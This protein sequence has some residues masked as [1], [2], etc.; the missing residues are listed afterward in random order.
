MYGVEI[1]QKSGAEQQGVRLHERI[2]IIRLGRHIDSRH[3]EAGSSVAEGRAAGAAEQ[4]QKF[5]ACRHVG[6]PALSLRGE[7]GAFERGVIE[8]VSNFCKIRLLPSCFASLRRVHYPHSL[9]FAIRSYQD[10]AT[11]C[12]IA[13]ISIQFRSPPCAIIMTFRSSVSRS[14]IFRQPRSDRTITRSRS[15]GER[16]NLLR[17]APVRS[18]SPRRHSLGRA[19][20]D[21]RRLDG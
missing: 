17:S 8:A 11:R 6:F 21:P 12:K 13:S 9:K 18:S 7:S 5:R 16:S 4:I 1:F 19:L 2:R 15:T 10:S 3:I 14:R 20:R